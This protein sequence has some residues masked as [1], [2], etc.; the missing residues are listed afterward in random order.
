MSDEGLD[1]PLAEHR[2][3]RENR[4]LPKGYQDILPEPPVVLPPTP[5]PAP[6]QVM[7]ECALNTPPATSPGSPS[8][9]Q[10]PKIDSPRLLKSTWNKFGL[11]QQYHNT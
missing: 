4:Q 11:S 10:I 1:Q 6:Q 3:R 5:P 2:G 7:L 9:Q 8:P